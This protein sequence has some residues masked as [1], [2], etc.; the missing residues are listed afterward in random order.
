MSIDELIGFVVTMVALGVLYYKNKQEAKHR[1]E[2][3]EEF[4]EKE[5]KKQRD[6]K[7]L[8]K[9]MHIE[10]EEEE[11][12][13]EEDYVP[14]PPP[15]PPQAPIKKIAPV[16]SLPQIKKEDAYTIK[17][18]KAPAAHPFS[19]KTPSAK[20][21]ILYHEIFSRPKSERRDEW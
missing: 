10:L 14:L 19:K 8:F 4:E 16:K 2:H 15:P 7:Q 12:E 11:E 9:E 18:S 3:P 20:E 6:L 17:A 1:R 13:E 5:R 21:M